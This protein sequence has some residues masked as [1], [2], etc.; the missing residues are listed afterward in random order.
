MIDVGENDWLFYRWEDRHI[1]VSLQYGTQEARQQ[2]SV[3]L[4]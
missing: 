2:G 1:T 3:Q 4:L